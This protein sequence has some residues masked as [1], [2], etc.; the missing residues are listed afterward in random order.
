MAGALALR[1]KRAVAPVAARLPLAHEHGRGRSILY[2]HA[3]ADEAHGLAVSLSAFR[4]QMRLLAEHYQVVPLAELVADVLGGERAQGP[5]PLVAV[6]FDDAFASVVSLGLPV[7]EEYGLP[8]TMFAV[9]GRLGLVPDWMDR[10]RAPGPTV[11]LAEANRWVDAGMAIE[12]HTVTHAD[13][14]TLADAQLDQELAESREFLR[15]RFGSGAGL[16]YPWGRHGERERGAVEAAGYDY[17]VA[18]AWRRHD[19]AQERFGLSRMP[20]VPDDRPSDVDLKL[21]GGYDWLH[22]AAQLRSAAAQ[23]TSH[24]AKAA[25]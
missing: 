7:L 25:S 14:T 16:S 20:V 10:T 1:I 22:T 21:R 3:L 12:S 8:A 5:R 11:T 24:R 23:A 2:Y 6:T 15:A 4:S 17:A 18:I 13:L 19:T 9:T